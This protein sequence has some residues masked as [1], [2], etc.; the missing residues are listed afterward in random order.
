MRILTLLGIGISALLIISCHGS[1]YY[2]L[3]TDEYRYAR[4]IYA[5]NAD[6]TV[7]TNS[8]STFIRQRQDGAL[9]LGGEYNDLLP[10]RSPAPGLAISMPGLTIFPCQGL[11]DLAKFSKEIYAYHFAQDDVPEWSIDDH[12]AW[13]KQ[14]CGS[15][16]KITTEALEASFTNFR[17]DLATIE[18]KAAAA[19]W[20]RGRFLVVTTTVNSKCRGFQGI[21]K[22]DPDD[23]TQ[24]RRV[25]K[26]EL[27]A[28]KLP[29]MGSLELRKC[30]EVPIGFSNLKIF[31]KINATKD[32]LSKGQISYIND[33]RTEAID[34]FLI[35]NSD[36]LLQLMLRIGA[37]GTKAI[38]EIIRDYKTILREAAEAEPDPRVQSNSRR[39]LVEAEARASA[40][41]SHSETGEQEIT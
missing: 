16:S 19:A 32:Q 3:A 15:D 28:V 20:H 38:T 41:G 37:R 27:Q 36:E 23:K 21:Y 9:E 4:G 17:A 22:H 5:K 24:W 8:Q 39:R 30:D 10:L 25:A 34:V 11:D 14:K 2:V 7:W 33:F 1:Y 40:D 31:H 35:K 12:Q 29:V 13:I 6:V 18:L 26:P